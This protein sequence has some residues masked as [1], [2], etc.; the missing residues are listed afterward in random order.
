M[1]RKSFI[2]VFFVCLGGGAYMEVDWDWKEI[3]TQRAV[4]F[5]FVEEE[6]IV[7]YE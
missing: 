3:K 6:G 4:Q 1:I 2:H 7:Y 5:K